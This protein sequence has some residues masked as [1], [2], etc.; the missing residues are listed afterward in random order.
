MLFGRERETALVEEALQA[1][2]GG[3]SRV[4]VV[5]GEP[6]VG[7]SALLAACGCSRRAASRWR[8]S[9]RSPA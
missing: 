2:Q 5:R 8:A 4:L 9:F 3:T 6:G 7:K 1:A